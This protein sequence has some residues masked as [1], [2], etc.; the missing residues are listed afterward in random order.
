[1]KYSPPP[2]QA[3][4]QYRSNIYLKEILPAV[5]EAMDPQTWSPPSLGSPLMQLKKQRQL[6]ERAEGV[7]SVLVRRGLY[8]ETIRV[9][10][11]SRE[12]HD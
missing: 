12:E 7:Q 4:Q 9:S 6:L 8:A 10:V 5:K 11:L 2:S 1:M 3:P